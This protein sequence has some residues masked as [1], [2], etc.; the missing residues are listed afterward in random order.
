MFGMMLLCAAKRSELT[1][2]AD[3]VASMMTW[4]ALVAFAFLT[5]F[6]TPVLNCG[7]SVAFAKILWVDPSSAILS[8]HDAKRIS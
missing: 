5:A 3:I 1:V 7:L 2:I 8:W 6:N 4:S